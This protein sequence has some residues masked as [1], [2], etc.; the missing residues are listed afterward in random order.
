MAEGNEMDGARPQN[1]S[2]ALLLPAFVTWEKLLSHSVYQ[3][4]LGKTGVIVVPT[5][6]VS[7]RIKRVKTCKV[8]RLP[9]N[10]RERLNKNEPSL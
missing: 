5:Y 4:S 9:A 7:D 8:L 1:S 2:P 10:S 6:R 3:L